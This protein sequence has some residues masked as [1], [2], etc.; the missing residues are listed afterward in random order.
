ME[1]IWEWKEKYISNITMALKRI[2]GSFDST[3]E[4][5]TMDPNLTAAVTETFWT[6]REEGYIYRSKRL[7][8]W[9]T[10]L[11]TSLSN[12][13]VDSI[14]LKGRTMLDVPGYEK[15]IEFGVIT[16]F[17]YEI[18][19]SNE[20]IEVATTRPETILGD[21]GIA[22]HPKDERYTHLVRKYA[23][24]P[25]TERRLPIFGDD[26]VDIHFGSGVVKITPAHDHNDFDIGKKHSL[27]FIN[28]LNDDGTMNHHTGS[29]FQGI[30]RFDARY[31]SS[32]R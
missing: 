19:R 32:L 6:L 16:Y 31:K 20:K 2:G 22:V 15:K 23:K 17:K 18:E 21:T 4:A 30:K 8:N 27:D 12:L 29:N 25:F 9:C 14:E 11:N 1:K 26:Y 7:V 13:E 5:F 3:R 10:A 28:I 24:H